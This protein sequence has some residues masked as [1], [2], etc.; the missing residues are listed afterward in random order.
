MPAGGKVAG[1]KVAR[2][3]EQADFAGSMA[4]LG[5]ARPAAVSSKAL[6]SVLAACLQKVVDKQLKSL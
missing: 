1:G 2:G 3:K 4:E 5:G 6:T